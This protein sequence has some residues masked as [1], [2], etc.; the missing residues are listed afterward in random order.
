MEKDVTEEFKTL[1]EAFEHDC[2]DEILAH[3][4]DP[5]IRPAPK[6]L[7]E[8]IINRTQMPDMQISRQIMQ[9]SARINLLRYTLRTTAAVAGALLILFTVGRLENYIIRTPFYITTKIS[10]KISN[11]SNQALD[12]I[13][14]FSSQIVN[15]GMKK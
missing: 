4:S 13:N 15:G 5:Q 11:G 6:Y 2:C 8:Q 3:L 12:F 9:T 7:K 14:A 1:L 10:V